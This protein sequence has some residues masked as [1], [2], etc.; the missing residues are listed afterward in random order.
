MPRREKKGVP[1]RMSPGKRSD[2]AL[3]KTLTG[4]ELFCNRELSLLAFQK[5]VLGEAKDSTNPL[6]ERINFLSIC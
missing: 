2:S 4:P 3:A 1:K 5:R 6:L